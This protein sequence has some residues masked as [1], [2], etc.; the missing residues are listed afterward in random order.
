MEHSM[1]LGE[2]GGSDWLRAAKLCSDTQLHLSYPIDPTSLCF[3]QI[4]R[5][6]LKG[7]YLKF[8]FQYCSKASC[9]WATL[10]DYDLWGRPARR[11][12]Y[13]EDR[14]M[15]LRFRNPET[16][17][18][19]LPSMFF[20]CKLGHQISQSIMSSMISPHLQ[21]W[22]TPLEEHMEISHEMSRKEHSEVH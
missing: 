8:T 11:Y 17:L 10:D 21:V 9:W 3:L 12:W 14:L 22:F 19:S 2:M 20:P 15:A 5:I 7:L 6:F 18:A 13:L 4:R 16:M 1:L